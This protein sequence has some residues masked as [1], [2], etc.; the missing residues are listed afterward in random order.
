MLLRKGAK[1]K[2]FSIIKSY[3]LLYT[4]FTPLSNSLLDRVLSECQEAILCTLVCP[5]SPYFPTF[6]I[7]FCIVIC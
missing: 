3:F 5:F 2:Y 4:I 1:P 7:R 6:H